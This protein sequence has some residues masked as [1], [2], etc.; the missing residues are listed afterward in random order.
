MKYGNQTI[1]FRQIAFL[2]WF[3]FF[4]SVIKKGFIK[5]EV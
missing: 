2:S 3:M 1:H 5:K 4:S